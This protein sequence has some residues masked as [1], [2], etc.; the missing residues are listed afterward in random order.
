M[1]ATSRGHAILG[2]SQYGTTT[3]FGKQHEDL[4]DRQ[5]ALHA[6]SLA[7]RHPMREESVEVTASLGAAWN[8]FDL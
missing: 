2:G 6:R 5:I 1:Q 7:F 8:R 4:R 3:P